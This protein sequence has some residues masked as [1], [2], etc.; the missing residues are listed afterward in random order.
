MQS[1]VSASPHD[2]LPAFNRPPPQRSRNMAAIRSQDTK[3]ELIVRRQVQ[4]EGFRYR[5]RPKSL[6]GSPDLALAK[7]RMAVFVH[8]CFWHGHDCRIGHIPRT[9]SDYWQ[10]K[11]ARNVTRDARTSGLLSDNGW[12][13][14]IIRECRL[15]DETAVLL[16]ELRSLRA[17]A[18]R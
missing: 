7:Y 3:L 5:L 6:P 10:A 2:P 16:E 15:I 17:S 8:G 9:N 4:L 18:N 1:T 14:R 13:V 12:K 11:I